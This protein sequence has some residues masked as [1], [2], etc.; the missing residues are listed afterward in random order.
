LVL[1]GL[2]NLFKNNLPADSIFISSSTPASALFAIAVNGKIACDDANAIQNISG[3]LQTPD[4]VQHP[5]SF[6]AGTFT[7]D[8]QQYFLASLNLP[9]VNNNSNSL[10]ELSW[11]EDEGNKTSYPVQ[12]NNDKMQVA[13]SAC[14]IAKRYNVTVYYNDSSRRSDA[15]RYATILTDAGYYIDNI[16]YERFTDSSRIDYFNE[17]DKVIAD[18]MASFL[19][20]YDQRF[21]TTRYT[22]VLNDNIANYRKQFDV[23][24]NLAKGTEAISARLPSSLTEI[25]RSA[26]NNRLI[27]IDANKRIIYYSTGVKR[28]YGTY[29]IEEVWRLA[30]NVYQVITR[31]DKQYAVFLIRNIQPASFELLVCQNRYN[32]KEEAKAINESACDQFNRMSYYFESDPARI[33]FNFGTSK[34]PASQQ[35]KLTKYISTRIN[36][37]R[38]ATISITL[39]SNRFYSSILRITPTIYEELNKAG[40]KQEEY[41]VRN[42]NSFAGTPFDRDYLQLQVTQTTIPQQNIPNEATQNETLTQLTTIYLDQK[43]YPDQKVRRDWMSE[44]R[45]IMKY[46]QGNRNAQLRFVAYYDSYSSPKEAQD[47]INTLKSFL[48][49]Q[50]GNVAE[51]RQIRY[52]TR[53]APA[54]QAQQNQNVGS[55]YKEYQID[56]YGN[57]FP[58]DLLRGQSK[59]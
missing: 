53:E 37:N 2:I 29:H 31:S 3:T 22:T 24:I 9:V 39:S 23:I 35:N 7:N 38:D 55:S 21:G 4:G 59:Q 26:T 44:L 41:N 17:T 54:N 40:L 48:Q 1:L 30:S 25:W 14:A 33:Y 16:L 32:T 58:S 5:L 28:T 45:T 34:L 12:L 50:F 36:N 10:L 13:I 51:S 27:T 6:E 19:S 52:D 18:S 42:Y 57:G 47:K 11:N 46:M 56:V 20:V 43:Y 8:T 49:Q 15:L